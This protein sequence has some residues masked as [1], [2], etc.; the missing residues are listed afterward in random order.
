MLAAT[1]RSTG[2]RKPLRRPPPRRRRQSPV[3]ANS[4]GWS[5][6][7]NGLR[8]SAKDRRPKARRRR[9]GGRS[10]VAANSD[11][12]LKWSNSG[13]RLKQWWRMEMVM[14]DCGGRFLF[15]GCR[16]HWPAAGRRRRRRLLFA[17]GWRA[18]RSTT[19]ASAAASAAN[20]NDERDCFDDRLF[21]SII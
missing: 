8:S 21:R 18:A 20:Q 15:G 17:R 16:V 14:G 3:V 19:A 13:G 6:L 2:R 5:S 10:L 4:D 9:E 12:Q 11:G 7:A 1:G